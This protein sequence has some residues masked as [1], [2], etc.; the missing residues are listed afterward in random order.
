MRHFFF[1]YYLSGT[2]ANEKINAFRDDFFSG[3]FFDVVL[4]K[5]SLAKNYEEKY[6]V[7]IEELIILSFQEIS[8]EDM[9][10][11][12][13]SFFILQNAGKENDSS[14]TLQA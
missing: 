13:Q 2:K 10:K 3:S 5:N 7:N 6:L 1:S 14:E 4:I 11:M 9:T 12:K 8:D